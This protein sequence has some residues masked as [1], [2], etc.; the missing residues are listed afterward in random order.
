M[1]TMSLKLFWLQRVI[2]TVLLKQLGKSDVTRWTDRANL[3]E[4]WDTR[5]KLLATLIPANS[6]VL[7]FG[8]GR[9]TLP[10]F[11]PQGCTYIPSDIVKRTQDTF[12]CDLNAPQLTSFPVHDVS[13][14]SGVLEY[15]HNLPRLLTRL[16]TQSRYVIA[17]YA[18]TDFAEQRDS[19]RR[20]KH[21]WVNDYS[22]DGFQALFGDQGFQ[23]EQMILYDTQ[24]LFRFSTVSADS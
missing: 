12:V 24:H 23:C 14:F 15:V 13:V 8:A 18:S 4:S 20:R 6:V 11:L 3:F 16:A 21:G 22:L 2:R 17:S 9:V 10:H 7:E 1:Q 5:T 19:L